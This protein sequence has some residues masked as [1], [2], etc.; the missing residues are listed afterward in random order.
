M[1]L[2]L[3][4]VYLPES[5]WPWLNPPAWFLSLTLPAVLCLYY[6]RRQ[7]QRN[8]DLLTR[9]WDSW[10]WFDHGVEMFGTEREFTSGQEESFARASALDRDDPFARNNLGSVLMQQ[11]RLEE[12]IGFYQDAIRR[13]PDYHKAY[14][15]L[16]AAWARKGDTQKAVPLYT[17][18]LS[19]NPRDSA[20]HLNLGIAL[21]RLGQTTRA[22]IHLRQFLTLEPAHP[23]AA[24]VRNFITRMGLAGR[25]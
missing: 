14:S 24:E 8:F 16:G 1:A 3:P 2:G 7:D 4:G 20:T 25:G 12:A 5:G 19:L 13:Y 11:G 15:N 21:A 6:H 9:G 22:A 10:R 17:K 23:K 18:A